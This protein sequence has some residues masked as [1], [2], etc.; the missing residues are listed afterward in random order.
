MS[1]ETPEVVFP[2][3]LSRRHCFPLDFVEDF[4][5]NQVHD[6]RHPLFFLRTLNKTSFIGRIMAV[7]RRARQSTSS[8]SSQ[9]SSSSDDD[10]VPSGKVTAP[11]VA[12]RKELSLEDEENTLVHST[13]MLD[14]DGKPDAN[15]FER[16]TFSFDRRARRVGR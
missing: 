13:A 6:S 14:D 3:E 9:A 4:L 10:D 7:V 5:F 11:T 2:V 15:A 16:H 1:I 12:R 8:D